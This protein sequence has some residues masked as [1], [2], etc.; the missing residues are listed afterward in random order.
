MYFI[1][2]F[3]GY[4]YRIYQNK[5]IFCSFNSFQAWHMLHSFVF[6]HIAFLCKRHAAHL[7]RICS[8]TRVRDEMLLYIRRVKKLFPASIDSTYVESLTFLNLIIPTR[9]LLEPSRIN[10]K[11][12]VTLHQGFWLGHLNI[13]VHNLLVSTGLPIW[14]LLASLWW[15]RVHLLTIG[16]SIFLETKWY[17]WM[18]LIG[19]KFCR[20]SVHGTR[21][22]CIWWIQFQI[23]LWEAGFMVFVLEGSHALSTEVGLPWCWVTDG[24]NLWELD[25]YLL[26]KWHDWKFIYIYNYQYLN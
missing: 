3:I 25:I 6:S 19:F 8:L 12:Q 14:V 2:N 9:Q 24:W 7:A 16:A 21:R 1:Y 23:K 15:F 26:L 17:F 11:L 4:Y 20:R 5:S 10:F 18:K 22:R 13:Q